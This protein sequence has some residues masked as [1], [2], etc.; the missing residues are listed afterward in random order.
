MA[1]AAGR[2]GVFSD[3]RLRVAQVVRNYGLSD[4]EEAPSDSRVV[5]AA[6]ENDHV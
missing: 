4:R 6:V 5:H 3:Y 1:Q 2:G